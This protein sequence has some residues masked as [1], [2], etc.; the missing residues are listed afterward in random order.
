[1]L[2]LRLV[3]LLAAVLGAVVRP[4]GLPA[5]VAPVVATAVALA[6]TAMTPADA[7]HSLRPLG[8][9]IAFLLAAIPLA[10]LLDRAG[11]FRQLAA[12]FGSGRSL[13]PGLWVLGMLTV[14]VLNLD[15]AVVLLTPLYVNIARTT[16]RSERSLGFQPVILALL[17][18]SFLPVSNLTNL[19]AA[20]RTGV[21]PGAFLSHLGFPG[22]VAC[23]AGYWCYR[24][25]R[26]FDDP[27][28]AQ[29]GDPGSATSGA[30]DRRVL[31]LG[32]VLVV[33]LLV[34]FLAGPLVG[35]QP[36]EVALAGDVVLILATRRLPIA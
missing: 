32:T 9:P 27:P 28:A 22:L 26:P 18:S 25:R 30:T 33:G 3:L 19:I 34:G 7:L 17:A 35:A 14:A 6:S 5:W 36:W 21:G 11:Y 16:G 15:A 23:I 29:S 10:V 12:L 13:V 31:L 1:V 4:R 8:A 20:A 2:A 24:R